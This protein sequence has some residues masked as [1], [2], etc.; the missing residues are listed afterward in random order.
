MSTGPR[1]SGGSQQC[2]PR[3][4]RRAGPGRE[5]GGRLSQASVGKGPIR[6]AGILP[7]KHGLCPPASREVWCG[8]ESLACLS[9]TT[10]ECD[11]ALI[12]TGGRAVGCQR[13][14]L[15]IP[16]NWVLLGELLKLR[17]ASVYLLTVSNGTLQ[18]SSEDQRQ[19][20]MSPSHDP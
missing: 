9:C 5:L 16:N 13:R 14:S 15:G 17:E 20:T 11:S 2:S 6:R 19:Q 4:Q 12:S 8:Q 1:G 3:G 18:G 7:R 10:Q